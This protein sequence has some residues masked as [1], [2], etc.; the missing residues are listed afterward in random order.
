MFR[1]SCSGPGW[2]IVVQGN[3]QGPDVQG[4]VQGQMLR[5]KAETVVQDIIVQGKVGG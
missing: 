4:N 3:V 2:G 1:D 5:A